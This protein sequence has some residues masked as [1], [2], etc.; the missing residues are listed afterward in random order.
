MSFA[1]PIRHLLA[2]RHKHTDQL[3]LDYLTLSTRV[4]EPGI[5]LTRQLIDYWGVSQPNVSR[6]MNKLAVNNL[7]DITRTHGG[8][9]VHDLT[10][11]QPQ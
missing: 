6:R 2:L 8:Y 3:C 7:V 9:Y 10:Q 11:L 1:I 4:R 5:I